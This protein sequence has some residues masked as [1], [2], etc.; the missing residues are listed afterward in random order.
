MTTDPLHCV[1]TYP[2][3][4]ARAAILRHL[5]ILGAGLTSWLAVAALAM[6]PGT[7]DTAMIPVPKTAL[8]PGIAIIDRR[9]PIWVVQSDDPGYVRALYRSGV[10]VVLPARRKTCLAL[11]NV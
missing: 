1:R 5:A 3:R 8:P 4:G 6:L 2:P 10:P 9:G 7:I 11:R